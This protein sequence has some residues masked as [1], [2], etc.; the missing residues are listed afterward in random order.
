MQQA[1]GLAAC[2]FSP[3]A[4]LLQSGASGASLLKTSSSM[5]HLTRIVSVSVYNR[6]VSDIYLRF[7]FCVAF[8]RSHE[9]SKES[10]CS[11]GS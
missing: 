5:K 7:G 11:T 8:N 4:F 10:M 2:A 1:E 9:L 3:F 6:T